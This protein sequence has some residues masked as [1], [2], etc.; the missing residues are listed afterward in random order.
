MT[1]QQQHASRTCTLR[2]SGASPPTS[3]LSISGVRSIIG[4]I[5]ARA[6]LALA[7]SGK[8]SCEVSHQGVTSRRHRREAPHIGRCMCTCVACSSVFS[9][10]MNDVGCCLYGSQ[11]CSQGSSITASASS[12]HQGVSAASLHHGGMQHSISSNA[13]AMLSCTC[14]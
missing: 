10:H 1:T 13:S 12:L 8:L 3:A 14:A 11:Q 6:P 2:G 9:H 4:N 7:R 5:R